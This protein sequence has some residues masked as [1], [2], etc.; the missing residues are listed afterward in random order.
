MKMTIDDR[1][2]YQ[3]LKGKHEGIKLALGILT[4]RDVH[5]TSIQWLAKE[6]GIIEGQIELLE[7]EMYATT[8]KPMTIS[9]M[10]GWPFNAKG[11]EE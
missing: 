7:K 10:A 11:E 1:A 2:D 4:R 3:Y 8:Y 9:Q 6:K 5:P